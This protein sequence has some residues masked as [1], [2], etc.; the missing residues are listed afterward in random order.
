MWLLSTVNISF[1]RC[2]GSA[3]VD[4]SRGAAPALGVTTTVMPELKST[5]TATALSVAMAERR[6]VR[7]T[8]RYDERVVR[9]YV[10]GLGPGFVMVS[11]VNDRVW[12]DGF[13]C[14]RRPDIIA[15]ADD[16][17]A[18]FHEKA[19]AQR[20]E[21]IPDA[22]PVSLASIEDLLKTAGLAFRL[23]TIHCEEIDPEVCY[24]GHVSEV[25]GGHLV[26]REVTPAAEWEPR[27]ESHPT[28]DIT[29]VSFGADYEEA[30]LL[31]AGD[32]P[33]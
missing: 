8:T 27:F 30:L 5:E 7:L 2:A 17:Y 26:M 31:V 6:L 1:P 21:I 10:V 25:S 24:I 16:P 28:T 4:L 23:V 18:P 15:I 13:E 33:A 14:F 22:P 20:G 29:R 11:V 19:L 12:L 3:S 32:P 9:G